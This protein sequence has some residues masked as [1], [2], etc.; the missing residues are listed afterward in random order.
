MENHTEHRAEHTHREKK[1]YRSESN[2][3][4]AGICG[5]LG[6]YFDM[7]PV[8]IRLFWLTLTIFSGVVPGVVA[9]LFAMLLVPM[10]PHA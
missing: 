10:R 8:I 6:E 4:I 7:D 2:K 1:L 9:Y 3:T 5:G